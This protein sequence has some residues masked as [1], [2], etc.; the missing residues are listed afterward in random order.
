MFGQ[1]NLIQYKISFNPYDF[2]TEIWASKFKLGVVQN[3]SWY[4]DLGD[5]GF[6]WQYTYDIKVNMVEP[7]YVLV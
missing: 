3:M 7:I 1:S 6:T 5:L 2:M 4:K